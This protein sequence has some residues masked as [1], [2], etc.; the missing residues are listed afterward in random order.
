[1]KQ[2]FNLRYDLVTAYFL[3]RYLNDLSKSNEDIRQTL[4]E[5]DWTFDSNQM[6][7]HDLIISLYAK[8]NSFKV[9]IATGEPYARG[10]KTEV[11]DL[12]NSKTP[13]ALLLDTPPCY[14]CAG[15]LLDG[16]P[17]IF[18]GYHGDGTEGNEHE[19]DYYQDCIYIGKLNKKIKMIEK[20]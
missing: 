17:V 1:M 15:T 19:R 18:G 5:S 8:F 20:R 13:N 12:L 6:I 7:N 16:Q 9:V 11:I 3:R 10:K 4:I 14:G 2:Y